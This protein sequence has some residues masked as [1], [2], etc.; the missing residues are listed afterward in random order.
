VPQAPTRPRLGKPLSPE[1]D[2]VSLKR[3]PSPERELKRELGPV[4]TSLA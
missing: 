3:N 4:S 1:R 2:G